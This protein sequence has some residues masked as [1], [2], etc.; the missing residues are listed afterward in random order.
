MDGTSTGNAMPTPGTG[1][2]STWHTAATLAIATAPEKPQL[3]LDQQKERHDTGDERPSDIH[4]D[5]GARPIDNDRH[6]I[7]HPEEINLALSQYLLAGQVHHRNIEVAAQQRCQQQNKCG[8]WAYAKAHVSV[9]QDSNL[10]QRGQD[11]K[12][13]RERREE[14]QREW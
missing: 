1:C 11:D 6:R 5:N 7:A 8:S 9:T 3:S 12:H 10:N 14:R 13:S 4:R 2:A